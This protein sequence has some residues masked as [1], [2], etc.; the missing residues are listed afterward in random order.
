ML[1]LSVA[2]LALTILLLAGTVGK[3]LLFAISIFGLYVFGTAIVSA[4]SHLLKR[5][6]LR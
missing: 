1:L 2:V 5:T 6:T 4:A 3:M